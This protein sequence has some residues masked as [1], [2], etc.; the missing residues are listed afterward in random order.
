[1]GRPKI[2]RMVAGESKRQ[3]ARAHGTDVST[4]VHNKRLS[5][6]LFGNSRDICICGLGLG[7]C[8]CMS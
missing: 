7:I 4:E 2:K 1:M 6:C 8:I 5:T 3:I